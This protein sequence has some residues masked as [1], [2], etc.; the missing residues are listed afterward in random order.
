MPI[1]IDSD[2]WSNGS[3]IDFIEIEIDNLFRN[4][5]DKAFTA[6]EIT[7][8]LLEE[9]PQVF[10]QKLL[11]ASDNAEWARLALVTSR[12][13]KKVWYNHAEVRSIDGNLYYTSTSGGHYPIADLEDKVPRKFDELENKMKKESDSLEERIDH[14]EYRIQEEIGYL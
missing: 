2:A 8:W 14:I 5:S 9:T 6:S 4:N 11:A 10:P 3:S 1:D 13:E 7:K 12:L